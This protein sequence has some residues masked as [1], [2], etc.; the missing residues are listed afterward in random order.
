MLE[1]QLEKLANQIG[2]FGLIAAAITF[3]AMA[4][5]FTYSTLYV[6][7]RSW[8]WAFLSTYLKFAITAI[9]I[10][11]SILLAACKACWP[12]C[13]C[14]CASWPRA[15]LC[16]EIPC[17]GRGCL[18]Q[19]GLASSACLPQG[20]TH[21]H[22]CCGPQTASRPPAT[23]PGLILLCTWA[24]SMVADMHECP[25]PGGQGRAN[26]GGGRQRLIYAGACYGK[27]DSRPPATYLGFARGPHPW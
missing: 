14:T 2:R 22:C 3:L 12:A 17:T 1:G 26:G 7:G 15:Y 11:V 13:W 19:P 5:Q 25:V 20:C 6:E 8:D 4:G 18:V 9:T 16:K 24:T 10:L 27:T 23:Y 21:S